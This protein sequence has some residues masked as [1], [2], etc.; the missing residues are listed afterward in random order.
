[1]FVLANITINKTSTTITMSVD[2]NLILPAVRPF[3]IEKSARFEVLWP[4]LCSLEQQHLP[5]N[6]LTLD[7]EPLAQ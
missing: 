4:Q 7:M 1:M 5:P 2:I 3:L 6:L